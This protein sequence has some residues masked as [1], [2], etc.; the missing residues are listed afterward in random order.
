[1]SATV[2][3]MRQSQKRLSQGRKNGPC[4]TRT[5]AL[6]F[7]QPTEKLVCPPYCSAG[8]RNEHGHVQGLPSHPDER[9]AAPFWKAKKW[10]LHTSAR[11]F[12]RYGTPSIVADKDHE[13]AFAELWTRHCANPFLE[14]ALELLSRYAR[15]SSETPSLTPKLLC[16]GLAYELGGKAAA[17][18]PCWRWPWSCCPAMPG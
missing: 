15:V 5:G 6:S 1:M 7:L 17:P 4:L 12:N 2:P 14:V 9:N 16:G 10:A 11:M 8:A 18:T 13:R 3:S